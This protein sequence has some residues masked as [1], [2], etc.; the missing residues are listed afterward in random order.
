MWAVKVLNGPEAGKIFQMRPG[1]YK[2]G[3]SQHAEIQLAVNSISKVHAHFLVTEDKLI[4]SDTQSRNGVFVNGVKVKNQIVKSGDKISLSDII[5]DIIKLPANVALVPNIQRNTSQ[6]HSVITSNGNSMESLDFD[7]S[8][9]LQTDVDQGLG[10][11]PGSV[12]QVKAKENL[13]LV[14][15]LDRYIDDVALPAVY[16]LSDKHDLKWTL[17]TF[18]MI[19]IIVVT[20]LAVMPVVQISRDFIVDESRRRAE[21]LAQVLVA[22]NREYIISNNEVNVQVSSILKEPGVSRAFIIDGDDGHIIAPL[23]KRGSYSK[24]TFINA[25]RVQGKRYF[26]IDNQRIYMSLPFLTNDE[27]TGEPTALAYAIVVYNMDKVA[28]DFERA[29]G[30]IIQILI[31]GLIM[32]TILYF[33]LYRVTIRPMLLLNKEIDRALKDGGSSI[34]MESKTPIIQKIIANINSS[35]S[36]ISSNDEEGPQMNLSD[37]QSEAEEVVRLF[38]VAAFAFSPETELIIAGNDSIAGSSFFDEDHITDKYITDLG[39]E[40]LVE[41]IKDLVQKTKDNPHNRHSNTLSSPNNEN[42]ELVAKAVRE[43]N[44]TSYILFSLAEIYDEGDYNE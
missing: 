23:T 38:S 42:F 31:I 9:A 16:S 1:T 32:G 22:T 18:V 39:N 11:I 43:G 8:A 33:F 21:S 34:E 44:T 26:R 3:R 12:P 14:E 5:L 2:V 29:I 35:L 7:G 41:N 17:G 24:N 15:K 27:L 40:S 13:S 28:L 37:K 25:A 20:V 19:F 30:L 10:P 36:R 6:Q 4:I